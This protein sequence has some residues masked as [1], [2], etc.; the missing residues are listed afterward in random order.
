MLIV[1]YTA[2]KQYDIKSMFSYETQ[3]RSQGK[4]ILLGYYQVIKFLE[5]L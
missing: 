3:G 1:I 2:D 5:D 4:A